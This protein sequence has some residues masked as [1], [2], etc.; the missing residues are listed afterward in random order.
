MRI[1]FV[2]LLVLFSC[3][4]KQ[5]KID[6]APAVDVIQ[7]RSEGKPLFKLGSVFEGDKS[8]VVERLPVKMPVRKPEVAKIVRASIRIDTVMCFDTVAQPGK[9]VRDT[10]YVQKIVHSRG[11]AYLSIVIGWLIGS[12]SA[13][14]TFEIITRKRKR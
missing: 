6:V 14:V 5:V 8:E 3:N 12:I 9:V 1:L 7:V 2:I 4:R 10:I 11:L 13:F